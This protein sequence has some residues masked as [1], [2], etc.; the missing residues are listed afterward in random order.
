MKSKLETPPWTVIYF[1]DGL[2]VKQQSVLTK[3]LP[4]LAGGQ[5]FWRESIPDAL[6]GALLK[7]KIALEFEKRAKLAT[8]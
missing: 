8:K 3:D 5:T 2:E 1:F 6:R 4:Q 7:K